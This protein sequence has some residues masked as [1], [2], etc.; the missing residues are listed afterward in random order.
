MDL[1]VK[2]SKPVVNY[3]TEITGVTAEDLEGVTCNLKD[4]Q[5]VYLCVH[6]CEKYWTIL[7]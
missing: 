6:N 3:L 1:L 7:V 5:V 4:L 2:P